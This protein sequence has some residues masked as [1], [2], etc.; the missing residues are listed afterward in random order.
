[1]RSC[2]DSNL[3][4]F[5]IDTVRREYANA[6]LARAAFIANKSSQSMVFMAEFALV[7]LTLVEKPS[8]HRP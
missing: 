6:A 7:R 1:L 3:N 5:F 2:G 4:A 8:G